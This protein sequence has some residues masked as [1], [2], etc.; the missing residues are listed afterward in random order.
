MFVHRS[1]A[2]APQ[3]DPGEQGAA[4]GVGHALLAVNLG[5]L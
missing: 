4:L 2:G 3:F 5:P 1:V